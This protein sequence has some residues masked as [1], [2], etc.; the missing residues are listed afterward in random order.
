MLTG[1]I[2]KYSIFGVL[3][4]HLALVVDGGFP[5]PFLCASTLATAMFFLLLEDYPFLCCGSIKFVLAVCAVLV[6]HFM[7]VHFFS[8]VSFLGRDQATTLRVTPHQ[9]TW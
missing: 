2:L 3:A 8:Q 9:R 4:I 1:K 6:N 5:L 7:W